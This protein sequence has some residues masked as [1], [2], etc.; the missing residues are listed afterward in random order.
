M[1]G[2]ISISGTIYIV[3]SFSR[4]Y[5]SPIRSLRETMLSFFQIV[6]QVEK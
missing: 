2:N 5:I 6:T 4:R 3:L 1:M